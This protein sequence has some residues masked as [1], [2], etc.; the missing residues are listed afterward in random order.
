M[1]EDRLLASD[2]AA[3]GGG[4]AL[5]GSGGDL[6]GHDGAAVGVAEGGPVGR[7]VVEVGLG[8]AVGAGA[9]DGAAAGGGTGDLIRPSV[10]G[11]QGLVGPAPHEDG[12]R[13][14]A[15]DDGHARIPR[16]GGRVGHGEGGLVGEA[17]AREAALGV[18]GERVGLRAEG[19]AHGE[20]G[21][22]AGGRVARDGKADDV[23]GAARGALDD[24]GE[25]AGRVADP[26]GLAA[27]VGAQ[28]G[29]VAASVELHLPAVGAEDEETSA[30]EG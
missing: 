19:G 25:L 5:G 29:E 2:D 27:A 20:G 3:H 16:G 11:E 13:A 28:A 6:D 14:R 4:L 22:Q 17:H 7:L 1:I 26:E 21:A 24:G 8:L 23:G 30:A 10:V 15:L 9:H 12:G 18:V